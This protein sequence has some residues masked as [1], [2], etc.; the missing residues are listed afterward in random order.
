[1][2]AIVEQFYS[3]FEQLDGEAMANCYH[4]D[5][6]FN[7]P[8]FGTLHGERAKNMWRML[9]AS[10]KEKNF[11]V[12]YG[13]IR[14]Q[15]QTVKAYWEARY[16]FSPTGRKVINRV[17]AQFEFLDHKIVKHTDVFNLHKWAIQAMGLKGALL[18]WSGFFKAQFQKKCNAMLDKYEAK[19][20]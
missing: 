16:I 8:A 12:D 4:H 19:T 9:C 1:M 10:Q 15:N 14:K 3:A 6:V 5:V 7:D 2:L 20:A 18:G 13:D 17:N 11:Q